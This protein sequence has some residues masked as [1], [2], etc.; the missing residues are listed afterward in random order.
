MFKTRRALKAEIQRLKNKLWD[1]EQDYNQAVNGLKKRMAENR[2]LHNE[3]NRQGNRVVELSIENTRLKAGL[4]K[5]DYR[6]KTRGADGRFTKTVG[7]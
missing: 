2:R 4:S 1:A 6:N 5:F 3:V 7:L